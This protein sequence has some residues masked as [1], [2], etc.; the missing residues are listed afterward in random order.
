MRITDFKL[1]RYFAEYEFKVRYLLS[2]SDC[3]ALALAELL[4]MADADTLALW[5]HL[6][7]SYTESQGH[8]RLRSEVAALCQ[9]IRTED[10]LIAA[11]EELIFI[12][13]NALL[14][15]GDHVIVTFPGYQ[16][17]Y[18]LAEALGCTVTRWPL[19]AR[20]GQWRLDLD[21]LTDHI[22]PETR[23]LVINFPH[24]PTGYLPSPSE[25]EA[26]MAIAR[27]RGIAVFSDEM[28]RLLEYDAAARLPSVTAIYERGIA[29]SGLSKS[30]AL[31]GLRIGWLTTRDQD[32]LAR[33]IA[34]HDYTTICNSAPAEILGIMALRAQE[35]ILARNLAIIRGNLALF[36]QFC[37]RNADRVEYLPPQAGSVAFPRFV[38][39][40]PVRQF[41]RDVLDRQDVM[42][43]P[44]DVFEHTGNHFRVGLGRADFPEALARVEECVVREA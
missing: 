40:Q 41:C 3:E 42:I 23:L 31:P 39:G 21:F 10:V 26:I 33:C 19:E 22:R 35:R 44:G 32:L 27:Q 5:H 36:A 16:S 7:L 30:F 17:L 8:P 9:T 13:M 6:K 12:A 37:A 1:E 25:F 11:P 34:F 14:Q 4:G 24:N 15:A 43:L 38:A 18:A 28:Y 29:I 2:A 20:A